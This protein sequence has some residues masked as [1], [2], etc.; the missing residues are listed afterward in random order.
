[1]NPNPETVQAPR[2]AV[3]ASA[4]SARP[5]G[6]EFRAFWIFTGALVLAFSPVLWQ[7]LRYSFSVDLYSHIL[8]IPFICGYLV[9]Q[10]RNDLP[11]PQGG[12]A[13]KIAG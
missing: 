13:G 8:L 5:V 1:M 6:G 2:P 4:P 12:G 3:A 9:W 10:Q 11:K 7:L